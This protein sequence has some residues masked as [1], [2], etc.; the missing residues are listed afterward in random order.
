[1]Q[2]R[3][4]VLAS[5]LGLSLIGALTRTSSA[6]PDPMELIYEGISEAKD[7]ALFAETAEEYSESPNGWEGTEEKREWDCGCGS[8]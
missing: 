2:Y 1:M 5:A 3:R 6:Y 4:I 7:E 8:S